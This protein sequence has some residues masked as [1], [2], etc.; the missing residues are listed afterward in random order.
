MEL[1][2]IWLLF[3]IVTGVAASSRGREGCL[4][5]VAGALL[6]PFGLIWVLVLPRAEASPETMIAQDGTVVPVNKTCPMCAETI[7]AEAI[8]CRYCGSDLTEGGG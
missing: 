6:G 3:A 4:W 8:K 5:S 7:K 2:L 1:I